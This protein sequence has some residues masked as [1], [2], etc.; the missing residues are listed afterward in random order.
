ME[1]PVLVYTDASGVDAGSVGDFELDMEFGTD[2]RACDFEATFAGPRLKGGELVYIDATEYGGVVDQVETLSTSEAAT[3]R[4]RTWHGVLACKVISPDSGKDYYTLSG[5]LNACIRTVV[6]RLGLTGLFRGRAGSCGISVT[7]YQ[8]ERYVD[9]YKGLCALCASKGAVLR[10]AHAADTSGGRVELWAEARRTAG[11]DECDSDVMEVGITENHRVVNHLVCLGEGELKDRVVV[12][13]YADAKG[14]VS[15]TQ[16]LKGRDEVAEVYDYN[17]AER[18]DLIEKGTERLKEYQVAGSVTADAVDAASY[19]WRVG[20]L[21]SAADMAH[22]RQVTAPVVGKVVK[23]SMGVLT[24]DYDVGDATGAV[25]AVMGPGATASGKAALE[26]AK[27][28]QQSW[29]EA[30]RAGEL[31]KRAVVKTAVFYSAGTK[32]GPGRAWSESVPEW[33]DGGVLWEKLVTTYATGTVEEARPSISDA[34]WATPADVAAAEAKADAAQASAGAAQATANAAQSA[35]SDAQASAD[36]AS[37]T[38]S[39]ASTAA[40]AA[41][42]AADAAGEAA[43]AALA[44]GDEVAASAEAAVAEVRGEV[45]ALAATVPTKVEVTQ[46]IDEAKGSVL[47]TVAAGY[48]DKATGETLATKSEVSQTADAIR[49]EVEQGYVSAETGATLATKSELTQTATAIRSEVTEVSE[50]ADAAM[51]KATTVEQTADGLSARVT[52][53]AAKADQTAAK[54]TELTVTVDGVSSSVAKAQQTADAAVTAASHA[55]QTVDGFKSTVEKT[56]LTKGDAAKAYATKTE[57]KQTTDAIR[58]TAEESLRKVDNLKVGGTN[59]LLESDTPNRGHAPSGY[60]V[61]RYYF[62]EEFV[63]GQKYTASV[64]IAVDGRKSLAFFIGGGDVMAAN[65]RPIS[66]G[67]SVVSRTF[68]ATQAMVDAVDN[69]HVYA[70]TNPNGG[71]A[72]PMTGTCVVH[73]AKLEKGTM[74]TDWS[75]APAD[76][77]ATYA[78]KA[79][80]SVESDRITGVV[81]EQAGLAGRVST[82]EQKADGLTVTLGQVSDKADDAS[83]VATNFLSYTSDGLVI[84][85]QTGDSVGSNVQIKPNQVNIRNGAVTNASFAADRIQL[86]INSYATEIDMCRNVAEI[87]VNAV[88]DQGAVKDVTAIYAVKA[89]GGMARSTASLTCLDYSGKGTSVGVEAVHEPS[90]AV[91]RNA[92]SLLLGGDAGWK[93]GQDGG[94]WVRS[95]KGE[96]STGANINRNL[97][98]QQV[99]ILLSM[100]QDQDWYV[101]KRVSNLNALWKPCQ[102]TW[103]T[104]TVGIPVANSY[105][106]GICIANARTDTAGNWACQLAKTT[107][108]TGEVWVRQS[109]NTG[110]WT[111]WRRAGWDD[112]GW[113]KL[114]GTYDTPVGHDGANGLYYRKT[115]QTVTVYVNGGGEWGPSITTA[116]TVLGTLPAGYRPDA[117]LYFTLAPKGSGTHRLEVY[118]NGQIKGVAN[119]PATAYYAA[120]ASFPV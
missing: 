116:G 41:K 11:D 45:G 40:T 83:K 65:W 48:V 87:K 70:S 38:A 105:G 89:P 94:L 111:S 97:T 10:M 110:G 52:Q 18:A 66:D 54:V 30:Y 67:D 117:M 1:E 108:D 31:S 113:R 68:T 55:Q 42:A 90:Q 32:D 69:L 120:T 104:N 4:G 85:D 51:A 22:N 86:G 35:A 88:E 82:V 33:R 19:D 77:D 91:A 24:V 3:Y 14:N 8:F 25:G 95:V 118:P 98:G 23:V 20:D 56:Y 75:P 13:L 112:T 99:D 96:S 81:T 92:V 101:A 57:V 5:D 72:N 59:L 76:A 29:S 80:L 63:V 74:A 7:N 21:L 73:W 100:A 39:A 84:A 15:Q 12:H 60:L 44:K 26:A 27:V 16:T 46:A 6:S 62:S 2:G 93:F 107:S 43:D 102:F 114:A 61:A 103:D 36:A 115:G 47:T 53:T 58:L 50:A 37:S 106:M 78:T 109:I 79:A 17:G 9:A 34:E 64:S 49:S 71:S 119:G 28:A